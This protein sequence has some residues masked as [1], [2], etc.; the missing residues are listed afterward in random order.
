MAYHVFSNK[1]WYVATTIMHRD[2][3]R[4]HVWHYRGSP[5]PRPYD[6]LAVAA[7][8]RLNLFGKFLVNIGAFL[9]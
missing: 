7:L 3:K 6:G 9:N 2:G 1:Q 5:D 4:N 8:G